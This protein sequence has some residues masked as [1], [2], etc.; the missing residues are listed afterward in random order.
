MQ[1]PQDNLWRF[2]VFP[3]TDLNFKMH[4]D[5]C[6]CLPSIKGKALVSAMKPILAGN[7]S[8]SGKEVVNALTG[9]QTGLSIAMLP[10]KSAL[11]RAQLAV[12]NEDDGWYT[13]NWGRLEKYLQDLAHGNTH[14]RVVL[15]KDDNNRFL[16]YFIGFGSS[17]QILTKFG[18]D[19]QAIDACHSR[20]HIFK[21][22]GGPTYHLLVGRTGMNRNL[23]IALT[24][25]MSETSKSYD[26]M[27]S[28]LMQMTGG[29]DEP[30]SAGPRSLCATESRS[31][32][33]NSHGPYAN[34]VNLKKGPFNRRMALIKDQFKGTD[35][36]TR[37]VSVPESHVVGDDDNS[38][39][40]PPLGIAC[41]RH[42]AGSARRNQIKARNKGTASANPGFSD[43]R[44]YNIA[45][46]STEHDQEAAYIAL[47][48]ISPDAA[49]Y[50]RTKDPKEWCQ[51]QMSEMGCALA[52]H[53]TSNLVEGENGCI[54]QM[55]KSHPL[56]FLDAY[57]L[58]HQD[59]NTC[60]R[61]EIF[62][63]LE[64]GDK[65]T[66]FAKKILQ[67][68]LNL[69]SCNSGYKIIRGGDYHCFIVWDDQSVA[70]ARHTVII[71]PS[72]PSCNCDIWRFYR[73]PCRHMLI[74]IGKHEKKFLYGREEYRKYFRERFFHPAY[75]L[76]NAQDVYN[77]PNVST[78]L[79]IPDFNLGKPLDE[80][81]DKVNVEALNAKMLPP[82][83]YSME[84]YR[85]N[86]K[87]GRPQ[88]IRIRGSGDRACDGG[89]K[90]RAIRSPVRSGRSSA[91]ESCQLLSQVDL[92]EW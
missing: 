71:D 23:T 49:A 42:V 57:V 47:K 1:N 45:R 69:S 35:S 26:F 84:E 79:K 76:R 66:P 72:C 10:S 38:D 46:A 36:F 73:I 41:A 80:I 48:R 31:I 54:A 33:D 40:R 55:R 65:L 25:S 14:L 34:L 86:R 78:T 50:L 16:Q 68:Q 83:K 89:A 90:I 88:T 87:R 3:D 4:S 85:S 30:I 6:L 22:K 13:Q 18:L 62:R 8:L 64:K 20:H 43:D 5:E 27:A 61:S 56:K 91:S 92:S 9:S 44:V 12:R 21:A 19:M 59:I 60:H 17:I 29:S 37:S 39:R 32:R 2:I 15:Q 28:N 75:L 70:K 52:G 11:N 51:L 67:Q 63:L 74:V 77:D 82:L 53:I 24:L 7:N 58:R 81:D